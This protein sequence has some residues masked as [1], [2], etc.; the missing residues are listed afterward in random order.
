MQPQQKAVV[1]HDPAAQ[2]LAQL[3]RRRFDAGMGESGQLAGIGLAG[4]HASIARPVT[5]MRSEITESSLMFAS[6]SVF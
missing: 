6:S 2:R 3:L 4:D 1:L 5:P